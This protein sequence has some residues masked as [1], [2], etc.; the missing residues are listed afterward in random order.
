MVSQK[1]NTR[2]EEKIDGKTSDANLNGSNISAIISRINAFTTDDYCITL[3]KKSRKVITK[4][5]SDCFCFRAKLKPEVKLINSNL[6]HFVTTIWSRFNSTMKTHRWLTD[7]L[8]VQLMCVTCWRSTESGVIKLVKFGS[9]K[10]TISCSPT[11]FCLVIPD[12]LTYQLSGL[13][14][15]VT[16]VIKSAGGDGQE[17]KTDLS[18]RRRD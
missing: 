16:R 2:S 5:Y 11:F 3:I 7:S 14:D 4:T 8:N 18:A 17:E 15:Q 9:E 10:L 13:H 6:R 1:R 12:R